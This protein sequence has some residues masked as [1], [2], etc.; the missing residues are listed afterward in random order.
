MSFDGIPNAD[1]DNWKMSDGPTQSLPLANNASPSVQ[2]KLYR[3]LLTAKRLLVVNL[4][5]LK[6]ELEWAKGNDLDGLATEFR[7]IK[8]SFADY[9]TRVNDNICEPEI[10]SQLLSDEEDLFNRC[11]QL[12]Y[13]TMS[14][15]LCDSLR[16]CSIETNLGPEDSVSQVLVVRAQ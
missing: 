7:E 6:N 14:D 8:K 2:D 16:D 10:N 3:K 13:G 1:Y 9:K 11:L 4:K 5:H 12:H 15:E